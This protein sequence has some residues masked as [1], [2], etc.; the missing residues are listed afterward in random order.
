MSMED[1]IARA[2]QVMQTGYYNGFSNEERQ[3]SNGPIGHHR[4]RLRNDPGPCCITGYYTAD[5]HK[6]VQTHLED[7]RRPLDWIPISQA[8]HKALHQR[9]TRPRNWFQLVG[10]H[11]VHG[12]WFTLLV[13][14]PTKMLHPFT[15]TYPLSLPGPNELW[16][17]VADKWGITRDLFFERDE[18]KII[19]HLWEFPRL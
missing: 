1:Y 3:A 4:Y 9:F 14:S 8:A 17:H 6:R 2:R 16:P 18:S 11:Y 12:A 5:Y 13:M 7:Y 10:E 15:Q 19:R